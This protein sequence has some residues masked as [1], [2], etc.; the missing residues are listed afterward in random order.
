MESQPRRIIMKIATLVFL[1][2]NRTVLLGFKQGE[3]EIGEGKLNAPG[4]KHEGNE[5]IRECAT[6]ETWEEVGVQVKPIHLEEVAIIT[7]YAAGM[8]DFEVH[9]FRTEIFTGEPHET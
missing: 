5:T 6:R 4:G 8:P 1:I 9:V 3:P 2:R 7:F